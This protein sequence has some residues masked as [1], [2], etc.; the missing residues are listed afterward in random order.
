MNNNMFV[1]S[2]SSIPHWWICPSEKK[3][4][5]VLMDMP[6]HHLKEQE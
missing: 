3:Q 6:A 5:A 1:N 2:A 4:I